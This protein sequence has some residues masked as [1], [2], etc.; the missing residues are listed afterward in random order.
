MDNVRLKIQIDF[1]VGDVIVP[2]PRIIEY[3]VLLGGDTIELLASGR[4][5][6]CGEASGHGGTRKR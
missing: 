3:P 4:D 1:G 2:G 6:H 5:G